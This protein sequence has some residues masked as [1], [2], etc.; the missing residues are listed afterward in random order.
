MGVIQRLVMY[1]MSTEI[2]FLKYKES[3]ALRLERRVFKTLKKDFG[4]E[5]EQAVRTL[6]DAEMSLQYFC[7]FFFLP[8]TLIFKLPSSSFL[9][10]SINI[11]DIRKDRRKAP[12][13][14]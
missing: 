9:I 10:T 7:H 14:R 11:F 13:L 8:P 1:V 2:K 4:A 3:A 12:I 6:S 5:T